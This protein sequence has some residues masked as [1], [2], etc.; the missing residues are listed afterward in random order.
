MKEWT[1]PNGA[2]PLS[3]R[4][5]ADLPVLITVGESGVGKSLLLSELE[6]L[7]EIDNTRCLPRLPRTYVWAGLRTESTSLRHWSAVWRDAIFVSSAT[8]AVQIGDKDSEVIRSINDW[9]EGQSWLEYV[10]RRIPRHPYSVAAGI[11][12]VIEPMPD[13]GKQRWLEGNDWLQIEALLQQA[14]LGPTLPVITIDEFHTIPHEDPILALEVEAGMA[15]ALM[16]LGQQPLP[17][18]RIRAAI[19]GRAMRYLSHRIDKSLLNGNSIR[20][21][22]WTKSDLRSAYDKMIQKWRTDNGV[23][24]IPILD[25]DRVEVPL[26]RCTENPVEYVLRHSSLNPG[27]LWHNASALLAEVSERNRPLTQDEFRNVVSQSS[28]FLTDCRMRAAANE[29]AAVLTL[30]SGRKRDPVSP[31][32][33]ES[34]V[35]LFLQ[36]PTSEI[37]TK[38]QLNRMIDAVFEPKSRLSVATVLWVHGL[39]TVVPRP[40]RVRQ[41]P[42]RYSER[43]VPEDRHFALNPIVNDVFSIKKLELQEVTLEYH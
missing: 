2:H 39:L 5:V 15:S 33:A 35:S 4:A 18:I 37:F 25:S 3:T 30:E 8:H 11:A 9:L 31:G 41:L 10:A 12:G 34:L 14:P 22:I 29:L 24:E 17:G 13:D 28:A 20:E 19:S 32:D 16:R 7:D 36:R 26:R 42:K 27:D 38:L 6:T 43:V 40:A 21:V 23:P 1:E